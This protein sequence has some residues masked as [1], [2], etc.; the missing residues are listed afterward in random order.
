MLCDYGCGLEAKYQLKSGKM[1]CSK[2]YNSCPAIKKKNSE[3]RKQQI[4]EQKENG[5]FVNNFHN[6][7]KKPWNKGITKDDDQ[8]LKKAS[9]T[10]KKHYAQG[11]IKAGFLGRKHTEETK[12]KCGKGGGYK[13]GSGRGKQGWYKGY[14]CDSS[15]E[16]AFVMY[17]LYNNLMYFQ[18]I[19]L[20]ILHLY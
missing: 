9:E 16:L 1:C 12:K 8:R 19:N 6:K 11:L 15:W 5:T 7:N 4:S 18:D 17:C 20:V 10:L 3:A 13:P 14:W 2:H